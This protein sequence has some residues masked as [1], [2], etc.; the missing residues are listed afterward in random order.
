MGVSDSTEDRTLFR[1][2]RAARVSLLKRRITVASVL[3]FAA[4]FGLAA[5]H[6]VRAA[7]AGTAVETGAASVSA[8][9]AHEG[10]FDEHEDGFSFDTGAG[11]PESALPPA[12]PVAQT[13]VS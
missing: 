13:S 6:V 12:P 8:G 1:R 4:F 5:Q 10:F 11:S 9:A 3:G 2:R 7:P